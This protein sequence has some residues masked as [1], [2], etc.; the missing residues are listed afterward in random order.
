MTEIKSE[1]TE[2][3]STA[4]AQMALQG[5]VA[6]P[7]LGS[8]KNRLR[9]AMRE[10][11]KAADRNRQWKASRVKDAWYAD[12]RITLNA[13]EMRDVE[14]ASGLVFA[15]QEMRTN[16][17]LIAKIDAFMV[18]HDADFYSAFRTAVRSFFGLPDRSG[19]AGDR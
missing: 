5:K 8:V 15:Q 6:P 18:G 13:D 16:D 4:F 17:E 7:S 19:T 12:E 2:M 1:N 14:R 3:N 9:V 10:L 11:N